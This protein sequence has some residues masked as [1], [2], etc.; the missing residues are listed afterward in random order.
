MA[1]ADTLAKYTCKE[2]P[3]S[4]EP[5]VKFYEFSIWQD[6]IRTEWVK[7]IKNILNMKSILGV[8]VTRM[9]KFL[10]N[11]LEAKFLF[12]PVFGTIAQK[13]RF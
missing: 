12:F 8:V 3:K 6:N 9:V 5:D 10:R 4:S 2:I 1:A 7:V 11:G 13:D